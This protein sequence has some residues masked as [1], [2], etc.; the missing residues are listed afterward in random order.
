MY[1]VIIAKNFPYYP[2]FLNCFSKKFFS[3]FFLP[4]PPPG[5]FLIETNFCRYRVVILFIFILTLIYMF[6]FVDLL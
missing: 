5:Y 3:I 4:P 6:R 2:F 1:E